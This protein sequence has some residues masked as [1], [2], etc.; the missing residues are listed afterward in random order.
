MFKEYKTIFGLSILAGLSIGLGGYVNLVVGGLAGAILFSFGLLTV[1][2]YGLTLYTGKSGFV[3][4]WSDVA[5]LFL[6]ILIGNI[7]GC[8]LAS[9][10]IINPEIVQTAHGIVDKRISAGWINNFILG[11]PC[12]FIMTVAVKFA[13]EKQF[14]PLLFGVPLFILCGFYHSIADAFYYSAAREISCEIFV[15]WI[16]VVVGNF[17]GCNLYRIICKLF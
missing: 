6:P 11:I 14:L 12:G 9:L 1:I 17:I 10:F 4:N 5:K 2:H 16:C 13:K 3:E 7:V 8:Y 15:N